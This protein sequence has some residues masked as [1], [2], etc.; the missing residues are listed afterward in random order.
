MSHMIFFI[1]NHNKKSVSKILNLVLNY[2]GSVCIYI[3]ILICCS[4]WLSNVFVD[5]LGATQT[6]SLFGR[7]P[8]CWRFYLHL[9]AP[10]RDTLSSEIHW[11][12]RMSMKFFGV[13]VEYS[14]PYSLS[15]LSVRHGLL[16]LLVS[17]HTASLGIQNP[18]CWGVAFL[19]WEFS[20][21]FLLFLSGLRKKVQ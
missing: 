17:L 19:W 3:F 14:A 7:R 8:R 2:I 21:S 11:A 15:S 20:F 6:D 18:L 13:R 1:T 5:P 16:I 10:L 12:W 4:H 9:L